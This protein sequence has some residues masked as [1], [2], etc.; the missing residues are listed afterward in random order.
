M[1][2]EE[3]ELLKLIAVDLSS[4]EDK[5][6]Q[7]LKAYFDW[8]HII[9]LEPYP[10]TFANG[11]PLSA[12]DRGVIDRHRWITFHEL[13]VTLLRNIGA[14]DRLFNK[15]MTFS[16]VLRDLDR[17]I[18]SPII[19]PPP[20]VIPPLGSEKW[21]WRA[22]FAV[23][24]DYLWR[25]GDGLEDAAKK[26]ARDIP[27][28]TRLLSGSAKAGAITSVK[29]ITKERSAHTS[30]KKWRDTLRRDEVP[31]ETARLVWKTSRENLA[32]I[33]GKE[34]FRTEANRLIERL[35]RELA[36]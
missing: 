28:V 3:E 25:A 11:D 5:A 2:E 22:M 19:A 24:L 33:D 4:D 18:T 32:G 35:R 20:D 17:G 15:L 26:L 29:A 6:H 13:T 7:K 23:A 16:A 27:G 31:D 34:G 14:G 9:L 30:I 10:D 21:R 8:A 12:A 36:A 1:Q